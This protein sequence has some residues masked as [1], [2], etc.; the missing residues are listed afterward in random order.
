MAE[1]RQETSKELARALNEL[2]TIIETIPD[3]FFILDAHARLVRWNRR[4]EIVTGYSPEELAGR[5]ADSFFPEEEVPEI[6]EA[7]AEAFEKGFAELE[8]HAVTKSGTLIP[9]HYSGAP[10]KDEKGN[11]IGLVG[12]GR[13]I[14]ERRRAEEKIRA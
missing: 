8:A 12:I 1:M 9:Y 5:P 14:T 3:V 7:I 13:D 11:V 2:N 6:A 10:L 4:V